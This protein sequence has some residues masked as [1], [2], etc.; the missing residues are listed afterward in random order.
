M[1]FF[2]GPRDFATSQ[3]RNN[4]KT[5]LKRYL[6]TYLIP[7]TCCDSEGSGDLEER[8][9]GVPAR[10]RP[11]GWLF[12][13][14]TFARLATRRRV[15][16]RLCA[17]SLLSHSES[18][19]RP[20]KDCYL[21]ADTVVLETPPN[22]NSGP[23]S[24][25]GPRYDDLE[26]PGIPAATCQWAIWNNSKKTLTRTRW[27]PLAGI[28]MCSA[29]SQHFD[30]INISLH[31]DTLLAFLQPSSSSSPGHHL[32]LCAPSLLPSPDDGFTPTTA[33]KQFWSHTPLLDKHAKR[34]G[35]VGL[36]GTEEGWGEDHG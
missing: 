36:L 18:R 4:S 33:S 27:C 25:D 29:R 8:C 19:P 12:L 5:E 17:P 6:E 26:G 11:A 23:R 10:L 15:V 14:I 22:S 32:R 3:L 28:L 24:P 20:Q 31:G 13:A 1:K 35:R 30:S 9:R 2:H 34:L 21:H 7:N 16:H